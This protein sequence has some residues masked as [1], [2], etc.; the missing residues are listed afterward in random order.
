MPLYSAAL[1]SLKTKRVRISNHQLV[2]GMLSPIARHG[3]KFKKYLKDN[4]I[5]ESQEILRVFRTMS[6]NGGTQ[7]N[8]PPQPSQPSQSSS[9]K[10]ESAPKSLTALLLADVDFEASEE[11]PDEAGEEKLLHAEYAR[12]S[13]LSLEESS[14]SLA[15]WKRSEQHYPRLAAIAKKVMA[16]HATAC[17]PERTFSSAGHIMAK[18]RCNMSD[19]TAEKLVV[20][21]DNRDLINDMY[22]YIKQSN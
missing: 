10:P 17:R 18:R 11:G 3:R 6:G 9:S 22:K 1:A 15:F 8:H 4:K 16:L 21:H 2:A 13:S 7:R 14:D 20:G 19:S 12:F 5:D